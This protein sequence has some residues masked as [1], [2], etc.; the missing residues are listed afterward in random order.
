MRM[1]SILG[2]LTIVVVFGAI[3][4]VPFGGLFLFLYLKNKSQQAR[5]AGPWSALAQHFGGRLDGKRVLVTRESYQMTLDLT[6]VSIAQAIGSPYYSD[7]GTYT[8]A[9]LW[10]DPRTDLRVL[11][12]EHPLRVRPDQISSLMQASPLAHLPPGTRVVLSPRE[13]RVVFRGA[14]A[15]SNALGAAFAG[16]S[17]LAE[18]VR[19][20]GPVMVGA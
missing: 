10:L 5:V 13:A 3:I 9:R 16:L 14:V 8:E 19:A 20:R 17:A 7:G 4:V 18:Q 2:M 1:Q 15:D 12:S 11:A 6:G